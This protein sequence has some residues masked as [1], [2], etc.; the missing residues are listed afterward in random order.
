[1]LI[2]PEISLVDCCQSNGLGAVHGAAAAKAQNKVT[3]LFAGH[4]RA[5]HYILKRG[6]RTDLIKQHMGSTRHLQFLLHPGKIAVCFHG[7]SAGDHNQCFLTGKRQFMQSVQRALTEVQL[8]RNVKNKISPH[9]LSSSL[10]FSLQEKNKRGA[11][12]PQR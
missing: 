10:R 1:M 7:F 12:I 2:V 6:I 9:A 11:P 3:S 4:C 8:C 5:V